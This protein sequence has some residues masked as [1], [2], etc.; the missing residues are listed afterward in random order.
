MLKRATSGVGGTDLARPLPWQ[1]LLPGKMN[2]LSHS[3]FAMVTRASPAPTDITSHRR[4]AAG[5][6]VLVL[7]ATLPSQAAR[8][9]LVMGDGRYDNIR[10]FDNSAAEAEAARRAGYQV[11]VLVKRK[12]GDMFEAA[13]EVPCVPKRAV[14]GVRPQRANGPGKAHRG[15]PLQRLTGG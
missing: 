5:L 10:E 8:V 13:A 6:A 2:R 1:P 15:T 7:A 9:A 4:W 14:R 3:V 12:C 11:D